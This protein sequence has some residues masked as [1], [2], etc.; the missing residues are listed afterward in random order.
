MATLPD[1]N[2]DDIF[3]ISYYNI[4]DSGSVDES[5]WNPIDLMENENILNFTLYDNGIEGEV[6]ISFA[7]DL[8][9]GYSNTIRT[10]NP[11]K[12]RI[13]SDGWLISYI[14]SGSEYFGPSSGPNDDYPLIGNYNYFGLGY[15][16]VDGNHYHPVGVLVDM[17]ATAG[18]SYSRSDFGHY[19][20]EYDNA[21]NI[22][23]GGASLNSNE[24][25]SYTSS[26]SI[27]YFP[28]FGSVNGGDDLFING[29][30][31]LSWDFDINDNADIGWVIDLN[32]PSSFQLGSLAVGSS[33][34]DSHS[35]E[36]YENGGAFAA[37]WG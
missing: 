36:E 3:A 4:I 19:C 31:A 30:R 17:L 11:T 18:Y 15:R 32:N 21:T 25:F 26:A 14:E 16:D 2:T 9:E 20:Y 6:T 7:G 37:I 29:S 5:V 27:E 1:L 13:K 22:S 34:G 12:F 10:P 8:L 24:S 33:P 35:I 23:Y 28:V